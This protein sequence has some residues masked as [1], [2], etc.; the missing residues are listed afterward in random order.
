MRW[1]VA[2]EERGNPRVASFFLHRSADMFH[3]RQANDV[4]GFWAGKVTNSEIPS[5]QKLQA[6]TR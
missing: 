4:N 3:F 5:E 2:N 1:M 6:I